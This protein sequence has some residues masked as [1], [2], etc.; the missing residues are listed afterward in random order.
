MNEDLRNDAFNLRHDHGGIAGLQC[1]DVFGGVID[2]FRNGRVD[3][4][5]HGLLRGGSFGFFAVAASGGEKQ[6]GEECSCKSPAS[7]S[8]RQ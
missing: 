2:L 6:C 3:F 5:W 8:S 4:D 7:D 1:S